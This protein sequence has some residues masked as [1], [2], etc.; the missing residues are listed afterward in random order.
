MQ[1]DHYPFTA[2][3]LAK[4]AKAQAEM[5]QRYAPA[6]ALGNIVSPTKRAVQDLVAEGPGTLT[7]APAI[8]SGSG[9]RVPGGWSV[10]ITRPLP[11]GLGLGGRTQV[12]FAV[13]NGSEGDV[14]ARKM[15]TVWIPLS[16][17]KAQAAK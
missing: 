6:R 3:P 7:P 2:A 5:A 8:S 15:R 11:K 9:K 12:A 1:I 17:G 16:V 4:D 14:G 13:W 10:A